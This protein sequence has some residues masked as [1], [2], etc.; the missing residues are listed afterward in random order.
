[1]NASLDAVRV[2]GKKPAEAPLFIP[3]AY[4]LRLIPE[5]LAREYRW[6]PLLCNLQN[7]DIRIAVSKEPSQPL[8]QRLYTL[9]NPI[10]SADQL[11][12]I[13]WDLKSASEVQR[14]LDLAYNGSY[15]LEAL[16]DQLTH[17]DSK[18][19][20]QFDNDRWPLVRWFDALLNDAVHQ[21]A[22]D[23]HLLSNFDELCVNYRVDGKIQKRL[24]LGSHLWPSVLARI[25]VLAT[26]DVTEHRQPQDG[27][28]QRPIQQGVLQ[29]RVAVMP[30][31]NTEKVTLR[32]LQSVDSLPSL[33]EIFVQSQQLNQVRKCLHDQRGLI[34]VAGPTGSG[35]S[36]TLYACLQEWRALGL[37][38][39]TLEDPIEVPIP[40]VCQ[41]E[42]C[43]SSN[44]DFTNGLRAALRHD[45]DG[46]LVG[47]IRD[48][49]SCS[50]TIQAALTGH[51]VLTTVHAVDVNGV[52]SRLLELG[53]P[54]ALIV[55]TVRLVVVQRLQPKACHCTTTN[56][57]RCA[58]SGCF[59]RK[60]VVDVFEPD[61]S[62]LGD[63]Q[64]FNNLSLNSLSLGGKDATLSCTCS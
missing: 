48:K 33:G 15:E 12:R 36:T 32:L 51:P 18:S 23:I 9:L 62:S 20:V 52:F 49:E 34:V 14:L 42:V 41:S 56:C 60:A 16:T 22:S 5:L 63:L 4:A 8:Q 64:R 30:H 43:K 61:F 54:A 1:V 19:A 47:E 29:L 2:E 57:S 10:Q 27:A 11:W 40:G 53:V 59:G 26:L 13:H 38:L 46:L 3:D 25:K 45:P 50:L 21:R 17:G 37:N 44:F 7:R 58:G 55:E 35:K 31:R 28:L 39:H 24:T 6:V